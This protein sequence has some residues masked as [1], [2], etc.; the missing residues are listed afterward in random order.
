MA[1]EGGRISVAFLETKAIA[2]EY[3]M[4]KRSWGKQVN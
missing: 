2:R 1:M 4:L 3:K